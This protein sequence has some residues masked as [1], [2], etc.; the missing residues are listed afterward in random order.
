MIHVETQTP[1]GMSEIFWCSSCAV[2]GRIKRQGQSSSR[3]F[4][5]V[6]RTG[7]AIAVLGSLATMTM[8]PAGFARAADKPMVVAT[9]SV[10]ADMVANV[11]GDHV[12]LATIV[13]P[14]GDAELY[15]PTLADSRTVAGA[16]I[17][18]ALS[19]RGGE[20]D[21]YIKMLRYDITTLKAGMLKN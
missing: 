21:T 4:S 12:E 10:L 6:K 13:G 15:E 3:G 19:K 18:D 16:R 1:S 14:D 20:A 11:A 2:F 5:M 9:F 17:G 7:F 8:L